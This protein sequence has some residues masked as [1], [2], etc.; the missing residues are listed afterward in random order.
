MVVVDSQ[1]DNFGGPKKNVLVFG[2]TRFHL[3]QIEKTMVFFCKS[4]S[5]P[6]CA[7]GHVHVTKSND[8]KTNEIRTVNLQK[9]CFYNVFPSLQEQLQFAVEMSCGKLFSYTGSSR[10]ALAEDSRYRYLSQSLRNS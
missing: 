8:C 2:V 10:R 4:N 5:T 3:R 6:P 1:N 9:F 7:C